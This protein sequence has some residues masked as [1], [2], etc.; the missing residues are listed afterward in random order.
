MPLAEFGII[1]DLDRHRDYGVYEPARYHCVA[2]DDDYLDDWWPQL[3]GMST[4]FHSLDRPAQA[5]ARWGV[6]L[7]PPAS[8]PLF[9]A[10][11]QADGRWG[12]DGQL[13]ALTQMIRQAIAADKYM[14][15]FG[16]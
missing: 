9:L 16:I 10:I 1:E 4:Y 12:T 7:I 2:I 3:M 5:L 15:H 11:V 6:T 14:I 13:A 8:L